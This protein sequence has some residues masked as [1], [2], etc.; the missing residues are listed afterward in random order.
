MQQRYLELLRRLAKLTATWPACA[1]IDECSNGKIPRV[2]LSVKLSVLVRAL[3]SARPEHRSDGRE[4]L[5]ELLREA[6]R[7]DAAV[8]VDMEQYAFK[9]LTLA[10]FRSVLAEDGVSRASLRGDCAASLPT[11]SPRG[12]ERVWCAGRAGKI[13]ASACVWS[14]AHIGTA[15]LPGPSRRAGRFPYFSTR[16]RPMPTMSG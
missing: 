3:R 10:I 6:A 9:D 14:K 12:R 13:G 8:T 11:D 4:R 15:R 2:N 1:Q 7:L 5:E 16:P